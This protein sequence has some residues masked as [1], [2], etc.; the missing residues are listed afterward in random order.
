[1]HL[2]ALALALALFAPPAAAETPQA[3]KLPRI[4][5]LISQ[6]ARSPSAPGPNVAALLQGLRALG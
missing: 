6:T 4:G 1:M 3:G 5:F 2:V